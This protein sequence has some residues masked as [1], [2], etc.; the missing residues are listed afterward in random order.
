MNYRINREKGKKNLGLSTTP[1]TMLPSF[2][3]AVKKKQ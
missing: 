3:W 1:K 2:S